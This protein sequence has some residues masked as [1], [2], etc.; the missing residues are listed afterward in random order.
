MR[1]Y[2][3]IMVLAIASLLCGCSDSVENEQAAGLPQ[4]FSIMPKAGNAGTEAVISGYW[5]SEKISD[6]QVDVNGK[7]ATVVSSSIDRINVVMPENELGTYSIKVTVSGNIAEGLKFRYAEAPEKEAL[8]V[9]SYMPSSG[10]EGD[11]VTVSG[12]CFS[13]KIEENEVTI[14]G[15]RAE[16]REAIPNK[17]VIVLP[18]NP[19]G[20]YPMVVKVGDEV[21]EGPLFTYL[22]KPELEITSISPS[23]AVAGSEVVLSGNLFSPEP[24]DNHITVNGKA[25]EVLTASVTELTIVV[26]ENPLGTYPVILTVGD[27]TVT[28]PDFT[29]LEKIYTYEVRTV[30]GTAGRSDANVFVDGGPLETKYRLPHGLCFL[31]DGRLVIGDRGNHAVKVMELSGYTTTTIYPVTGV[32]NLLNNPWRLRADASGNLFIA[33]KANKKIVRYDFSTSSAEVVIEGLGDPL[34]VCFDKAGR[35]Y[36]MDRGV[37]KILRYEKGVYTDP[38]DFI[39]FASEG[40]LCMD[41]DKDGNLIVA[42]N[43]FHFYKVS[44]DGT[45]EIIAGN[46]VKGSSDGTLREPLTAS[47]G[48]VYGLSIAP[49]GIIYFVDA[50]YHTVRMINPGPDGYADASV[51]TVAGKSGTTGKADGIGTSTTFYM[52]YDICASPSGDKLYV[53]DLM[54]FLIREITIKD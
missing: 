50:T 5:F 18:D 24:A 4:L 8:T 38:V 34:D 6:I 16:I 27:K 12:L 37:K 28:G 11:E 13:H 9:Y 17:M 40:P 48:E 21:A 29:Y 36:V 42:T 53:V 19:Q 54:N 10:I 30:S 15:V 1:K 44:P 2:Y 49:D 41:F 14:N 52:P 7:P 25:A 26:P 47:F 35:L 45:A 51:R 43:G 31:P 33:S 32:P 46:G 39:T 22:K 20:Q 3:A 23:S